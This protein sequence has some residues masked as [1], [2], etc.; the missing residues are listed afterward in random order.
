MTELRITAEINE[1]FFTDP[2]ISK[3]LLL[4]T[5]LLFSE[6]PERYLAKL[7][8]TY[9]NQNFFE[10]EEFLFDLYLQL[11]LWQQNYCET[12]E[13]KRFLYVNDA[14]GDEAPFAFFE[15]EKGYWKFQQGH[16]IDFPPQYPLPEI[17]LSEADFLETITLFLTGSAQH[18]KSIGCPL[19][20]EDYLHKYPWYPE[21]RLRIIKKKMTQQTNEQQ[22]TQY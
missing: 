2:A 5:D 6:M 11:Y 4:N 18:L 7:T 14:Y 12:K 19:S 8:F 9:K 17:V 22:A 10:I 13:L 1:D 16:L 21:S 15:I 3:T 20:F